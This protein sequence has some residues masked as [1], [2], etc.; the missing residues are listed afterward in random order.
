MCFVRIV[1]CLSQ[2]AA[3]AQEVPA[4]IELDLYRGKPPRFGVVKRCA[5]EQLVLFANELLNMGEYRCFV[6]VVCHSISFLSFQRR[7]NQAR[8]LSSATVP[9]RTVLSVG[10]A[11]ARY[12]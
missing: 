9:T 10:E 8:A 11:I 3:L 12:W 2:R 1:A 6:S 4:L 5:V 7:R